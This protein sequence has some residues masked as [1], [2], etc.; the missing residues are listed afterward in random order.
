MADTLSV[1]GDVH[2]GEPLIYPVMASGRRI[3]PQASLHD[4]RAHARHELE[5]LPAELRELSPM[6]P[7]PVQVSS[8]LEQL[9]V[10]TD[11]RLSSPELLP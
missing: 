7:Y 1:E 5:W 2:D 9:A 10:V 6:V 3:G 11:Q 8:S 4:I